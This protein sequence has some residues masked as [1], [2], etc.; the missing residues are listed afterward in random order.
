MECTHK[1]RDLSPNNRLSILFLSPRFPLSPSTLRVRLLSGKLTGGLPTPLRAAARAGTEL[2]KG[3]S[4]ERPLGLF[5]I[6]SGVVNYCPT[7]GDSI[8]SAVNGERSSR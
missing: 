4:R 3:D 1:S 6:Y 7:Y 5:P 2:G 8:A